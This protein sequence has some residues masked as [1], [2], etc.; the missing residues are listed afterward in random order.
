MTWTPKLRHKRDF[1]ARCGSKGFTIVELVVVLVIIG[2]LTAIAV[3]LGLGWRSNHRFTAMV[4]AFPTAVF[5][6]RMRGIENRY[7][8]TITGSG[9]YATNM[10]FSTSCP[11]IIFTTNV[12]HGFN[13]PNPIFSNTMVLPPPAPAY[14]SPIANC[15]CVKNLGAP[16]TTPTPG[17]TV[18]ITGLDQ[19]VSMNGVEF[20]V[21][22]TPATNQFTVQHS[23]SGVGD[24]VAADSTGAVRQLTAPGRLKIFPATSN[25]APSNDNQENFGSSDYT[26]KEEGA[27]IVFR[28]DTS[29]FQAYINPTNPRIVNGAP[30]CDNISTT[31]SPLLDPS[32]NTSAQIAF[33]TRGFLQGLLAP[34]VAAVL[35]GAVQ[36]WIVET[37]PAGMQKGPRQ[38]IYN[39]GQTGKVDTA[40]SYGTAQDH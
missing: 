23:W 10:P 21:I 4:R 25:S 34:T 13:L 5:M 39:I 1:E 29:R 12:D 27:N 28:Y 30:V 19:H 20:E 38:A 32:S 11:G 15:Q 33:D 3:P 35:P 6:A 7:V 9:S 31:P 17:D 2:I 26:L 14:W 40:Y 37:V 16:T 24:T 36:I 22:T 18:M 8:I